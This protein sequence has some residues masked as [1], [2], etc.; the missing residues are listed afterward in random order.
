[1]GKIIKELST[2]FG[3]S[4]K[5]I[6]TRIEN[7]DRFYK[8]IEV[9]KKSG[10]TR[11]IFLPSVELKAMQHYINENYLSKL[12]VSRFATAYVKNR[13]IVDNVKPHLKNKFFLRID[14]TNFF[15]SINCIL[16]KKIISEFF[17]KELN[18]D[19]VNDLIKIITYKGIFV[20]G[21]VT[22]PRISNIM[23]YEI[24]TIIY[25]LIEKLRN[26]VYTR[27]SDDITISS[28]ERIP[29]D[30][31]LEIRN[32]LIKYNLDIN[33]KK[34]HYSGKSNPRLTGINIIENKQLSLGSDFKKQ[35]KNK[36]FLVLKYQN[37]SKVSINSVIGSLF[38]LKMVEPLY[39]N[40][41]NIKYGKANTSLIK[42]LIAIEKRKHQ[43]Q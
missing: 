35:L 8:K 21:N 5:L 17:S 30:V 28:I 25:K 43:E 34:S 42:T 18:D 26:G 38:Y 27:Y 16:V 6:R 23:M 12:P 13:S 2:I 19:D 37:E 36:I 39:F 41:L 31:F 40:T 10:G 3:V 14:L 32:V 15:D 11:K 29:S 1:M 4:E 24:D 9:K 33:Q 22:S 20:Q 7:S